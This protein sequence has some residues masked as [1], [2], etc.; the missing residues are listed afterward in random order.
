VKKLAIGG[1]GAGVGVGL[2]LIGYHEGVAPSAAVVLRL[3]LLFAVPTTLLVLAAL[4]AFRT[5]DA[6]EPH[7]TSF[8]VSVT[9]GARIS[10]VSR[11]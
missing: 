10:S 9:P 2:T 3:Q 4:W 8:D 11:F 6:R 7:L 1:A 5:Y